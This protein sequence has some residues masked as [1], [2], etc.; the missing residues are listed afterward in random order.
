MQEPTEWKSKK[1]V[2][3]AFDFIVGKDAFLGMSGIENG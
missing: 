3:E 1:K 2:G